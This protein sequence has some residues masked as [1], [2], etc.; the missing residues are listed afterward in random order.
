MIQSQASDITKMETFWRAYLQT[1][2]NFT[3]SAAPGGRDGD[4][5]LC[6]R[7]LPPW[8]P[9]SQAYNV[10]YRRQP[11]LLSN[12]P[13]D[14]TLHPTPELSCRK[15]FEKHVS[16]REEIMIGGLEMGSVYEVRLL[17]DAHAVDPTAQC[18][19][20]SRPRRHTKHAH[21]RARTHTH[22]HTHNLGLTLLHMTLF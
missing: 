21:A 14:W 9:A 4:Y 16:S 6:V 13:V 22:T 12:D 5:A 7:V 15:N 2:P 10:H 3:L 20:Y 1:R 11:A 19:V 17:V 18:W 8:V